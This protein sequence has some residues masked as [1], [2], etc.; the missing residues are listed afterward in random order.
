MRLT[1]AYPDTRREH[2]PV[3]P[4]GF[5]LPAHQYPRHLPR[6]SLPSASNAFP[7]SSNSST[8]SES[9]PSTLDSPCKSPDCSPDRAS[10][11]PWCE[12]Y[13]FHAVAFLPDPTFQVH[14]LFFCPVVLYPPTFTFDFFGAVF[15]LAN[16]LL[17]DSFFFS[18]LGFGLLSHQCH[19]IACIQ[20]DFVC[21]VR[22]PLKKSSVSL[23]TFRESCL[24]VFYGR[25]NLQK[26]TQTRRIG[27]R[28]YPLVHSC[29]SEF[30]RCL[31]RPYAG[32]NHYTKAGRS[33]DR[34]PL[35]S[36]INSGAFFLPY[37]IL[38]TS[39]RLE[40][41]PAFQCQNAESIPSRRT[42]DNFQMFTAHVFT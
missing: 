4:H 38:K 28:F 15:F 32:H 41:Q 31:L 2:R 20:V 7:S 37:C 34:T 5:K 35:M 1:T 17:G 30:A 33:M 29:K 9:A 12:R 40:S 3:T 10:Q 16:L 22:N 26:L 36:I 14:V 19:L 27:D 18:W 6:P 23:L 11:F 42:C 24:R 39:R 21:P 13:S 8:L 25:V